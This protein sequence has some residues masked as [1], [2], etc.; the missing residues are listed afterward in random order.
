MRS[1]VRDYIG[2]GCDLEI[3]TD[4]IEEH[5]QTRGYQT[6]KGRK[7]GGWMVQ[8]RKGGELRELLAADRVFT[9]VVTGG[10]S[11]FRVTFGLGKW[12]ESP[13]AA[14]VEQIAIGPV[15]A[16]IEIPVGLS[17]EVEREFWS[18]VEKQVDLK[19]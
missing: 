11:N 19:G 17:R 7:E 15:V 13:G 1:A 8:A 14:V 9:V 3:L 18:H 5:F 6:Q 16:H 12:F 10:P 4:S 2:R